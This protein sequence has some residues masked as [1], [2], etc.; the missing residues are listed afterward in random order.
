MTKRVTIKFQGKAYAFTLSDT[1][2]YK[3]SHVVDKDGKVV[4]A[5]EKQQRQKMFQYLPLTMKQQLKGTYFQAQDIALMGK[6]DEMAGYLAAGGAIAR[7]PE[8]SLKAVG[9]LWPGGDSPAEAYAKAGGE[10]PAKAFQSEKHSFLDM[11][12]AMKARYPVSSAIQEGVVG[13]ASGAGYMKVAQAIGNIASKAPQV[14]RNILPTRTGNYPLKDRLRY[15]RVSEPAQ[16]LSEFT[17]RLAGSRNPNV[18]QAT[19]K[20]K[21]LDTAKRIAAAATLGGAAAGDYGYWSGEGGL[22]L[23]G[24]NIDER[25]RMARDALPYGA[26]F[27]TALQTLPSA[28]RAAKTLLDKMRGRQADRPDLEMGYAR[29]EDYEAGAKVIAEADLRDAMLAAGEGTPAPSRFADDAAMLADEGTFRPLLAH[30]A[31]TA[32]GESVASAAARQ[33]VQQRAETAG[34]GAELGREVDVR[35]E[36]ARGLIDEASIRKDEAYT[37]A[38]ATADRVPINTESAIYRDLMESEDFDA[39]LKAARRERSTQPGVEIGT[40]YPKTKEEL[41]GGYRNIDENEV[42][43]YNKKGWEIEEIS[44]EGPVDINTGLPR[45]VTLYR[46]IDPQG[47]GLNLRQI[48]EI[49]K[50]FVKVV[51]KAEGDPQQAAIIDLSNSFTG[52]FIT[53]SPRLR[54]AGQFHDERLRLDDAA[55]E[56]PSTLLA[57][58]PAELARKL[59]FDGRAQEGFPD[60]KPRSAQQQKILR[61]TLWDDISRQVREA[62]GRPSQS[63][64]DS[65]EVLMKDDKAGFRIWRDAV[66]NAEKY[67]LSWDSFGR[68]YDP[69]EDLPPSVTEAVGKVGRRMAEFFFSA[70]FA[71]ARQLDRTLSKAQLIRNQAVNDA[72]VDM[73]TKTGPQKTKA[74]SLVKKA[75][76]EKTVSPA[77]R[78]LVMDIFRMAV[79][80]GPQMEDAAEMPYVGATARGVG[81]GLIGTGKLARGLIPGVN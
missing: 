54:M 73:L 41:L 26:L 27:G 29:P 42:A 34:T 23:E 80:L 75:M 62:K 13:G 72:V 57:L 22:P 65:V 49:N 52:N 15:D 81:Y 24:G 46:A 10:S 2:Y 70:P 40:D 17:A 35:G 78:K 25:V 33:R 71:A 3:L 44:Q 51:S 39:V 38:E 19:S 30:A 18:A 60:G 36:T 16:D 31:T 63:L 68:A 37:A 74:E 53:K 50:G 59:E 7:S 77:D 66:R 64:V 79:G 5:T 28:G 4:A 32:G 56:K 8:A 43:L 6:A 76:S 20:Y 48:N 12:D 9:A 1:D 58:K 14:A 67:G 61:E 45:E 11:L 21:G 47:P 69:K 55:A